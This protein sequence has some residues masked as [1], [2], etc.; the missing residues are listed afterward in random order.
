MKNVRIV[1]STLTLRETVRIACCKRARLWGVIITS[2]L[3]IAGGGVTAHLLYDFLTARGINLDSR[4]FNGLNGQIPAAEKLAAQ[5]VSVIALVRASQYCSKN[6]AFFIA[7]ISSSRG[8]SLIIVRILRL[9]DE[10]IAKS[11]G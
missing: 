11:R 1:R 5:L 8:F 7:A 9:S 3:I 6:Y 2:E 4:P 10:N